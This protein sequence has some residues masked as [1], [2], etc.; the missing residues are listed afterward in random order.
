MYLDRREFVKLGV[1]A[2][3]AISISGILLGCNTKR[4]VLGNAVVGDIV[5]LGRVSF[6]DFWDGEFSRDIG[7][8]VLAVENDRI[9]VISEEIIDLRFYLEEYLTG[10]VWASCGLRAWLNE[11]FYDGL[12]QDIQELVLTSSVTNVIKGREEQSDDKM[13]LLSWDEVMEFFP[14][15]EDRKAELGLS[16]AAYQAFEEENGIGLEEMIQSSYES[17]PW[18]ERSGGAVINFKKEEPVYGDSGMVNEKISVT[19]Y[20]KVGAFFP[21]SV[22]LYLGGVFNGV[23]PAMW[24]KRA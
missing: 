23:R 24:L 2:G 22:F 10:N 8:R 7:W 3:A 17:C 1:A 16:D 4:L 13:F 19:Y 6:I 15:E 21:T 12:P 9:L 14:R 18:W 20:Q 5:N 11:E